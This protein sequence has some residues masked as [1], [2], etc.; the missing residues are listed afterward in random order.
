[1]SFCTLAV[2]VAAAA[3]IILVRI[4]MRIWL[5]CVLSSIVVVV[6]FQRFCCFRKRRKKK[7]SQVFL[8]VESAH[9]IRRACFVCAR[10]ACA[11]HL[12]SLR[13]LCECKQRPPNL[14]ITLQFHFCKRIRHTMKCVQR[15]WWHMTIASRIIWCF[16]RFPSQ[17]QT[18]EC[19]RMRQIQNSTHETTKPFCTY[20]IILL[21]FLVCV[22]AREVPFVSLNRFA[23]THNAHVN[24]NATSCVAITIIIEQLMEYSAQFFF[25]L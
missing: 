24:L 23:F 2:A 12:C 15:K 25:S 13:W 14:L 8:H 22:C 17:S 10:H 4:W 6:C 9:E 11:S 21:F 5:L 20:W 3:A 19:D 1:M 7:R 18:R 16:T